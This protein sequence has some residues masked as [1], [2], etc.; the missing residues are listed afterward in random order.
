[1]KLEKSYKNLHE[2]NRTALREF[3]EYR[4][5]KE[6]KEKAQEIIAYYEDAYD[7]Y[8]D[9]EDSRKYRYR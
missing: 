2:R 3:L 1:L 4:K 5:Q 6:M 7:E 8:Q 9:D